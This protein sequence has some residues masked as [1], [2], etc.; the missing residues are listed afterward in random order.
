MP[1]IGRTKSHV[2]DRALYTRVGG[3]YGFNPSPEIITKNWQVL[4]AVFTVTPLR[5][6]D[7]KWQ[8]T[9]SVTFAPKC[10]ISLQKFQENVPTLAR[11]L[12]PLVCPLPPFHT[13]PPPT[14]FL[15]TALLYTEHSNKSAG[16]FFSGDKVSPATTPS[17]GQQWRSCTFSTQAD[18][19]TTARDVIME[20]SLQ[21]ANVDWSATFSERAPHRQSTQHR[22]E[23]I[24]HWNTQRK[25]RG[26]NPPPV[27]S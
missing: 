3:G 20:R 27:E 4:S 11:G 6:L 7:N 5:S 16:C 1:P 17:G 18:E 21:T 24:R 26:F 12:R 10:T 13:E 19:A 22:A 14:K 23:R 15:A 2:V 8:C 25:V 9:A